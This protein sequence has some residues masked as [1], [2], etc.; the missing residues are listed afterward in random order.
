M[1]RR[2]L[3]E[4]RATHQSRNDRRVN[5]RRQAESLRQAREAEEIARR[6]AE[7]D[8]IPP[9]VREARD[10]RIQANADIRRLLSKA[11]PILSMAEMGS[12]RP[13]AREACTMALFD[14]PRQVVEDIPHIVGGKIIDKPKSRLGIF[15]RLSSYF[16]ATLDRLLVHANRPGSPNYRG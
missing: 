12:S 16:D 9:E 11:P 1:F 4:K 2:G 14:P 5:L 15:K 10:Q 3:A 6:Q 7:E 13:G 8:A